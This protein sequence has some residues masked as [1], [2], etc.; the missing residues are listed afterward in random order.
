MANFRQVHTKIWKD[1]WFLD[2]KPIHK[3]FFIYLFTNERASLAG[4]Y[5]LPMRV[6]S[7]ESGLSPKEID[8]AFQVFTEAQKAH[9]MGGV[10]WVMSL[11]RYHETS[12][13]KVQTRILKDLAEV[14]ECELKGIYCELYGI[15]TLSVEKNGVSIPPYTS[16]IV[17]STSKKGDARGKKKAFEFT[18]PTKLDTPKFGYAWGEYVEN[19]IDMGYPMT[20]R[21]ANMQLKKLATHPVSVAT[22]AVEKAV[23]S[24]WRSVYPEKIASKNGQH[25]S[26]PASQVKRAGEYTAEGRI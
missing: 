14:K 9:Y 6:M 23:A 12:S 8:G 24:N 4:I 16:S 11:R 5:E 20:S 15:D 26:A 2:L 10:V 7:F 18:I 13:S 1:D 22:L 3:L 21:A 17:S 25:G 19:R